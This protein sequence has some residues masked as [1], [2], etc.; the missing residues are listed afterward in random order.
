MIIREAST[1]VSKKKIFFSF[2]CLNVLLC[3]YIKS[4]FNLDLIYLFTEY[5][6]TFEANKMVCVFVETI[7]IS[8]KS[9][10]TNK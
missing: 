6:Y 10:I 4:I 2:F 3:H 7:Y 9:Y 5:H 8:L 1:I